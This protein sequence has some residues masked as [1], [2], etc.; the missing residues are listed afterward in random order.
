MSSLLA[1]AT[2]QPTCDGTLVCQ[3]VCFVLIRYGL[4]HSSFALPLSSMNIFS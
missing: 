1:L 3:L 4:C 2:V